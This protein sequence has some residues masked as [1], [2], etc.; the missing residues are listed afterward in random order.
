MHKHTV[1]TVN[2]NT[3]KRNSQNR[4]YEFVAIETRTDEGKITERA[5]IWSGTREGAQKEITYCQNRRAKNIAEG[6]FVSSGVTT[7]TIM[8][9]TV[10]SK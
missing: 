3:L 2:G 9:P 7:Y 5:L 1:T 6:W 4:I 10:I 8:Q